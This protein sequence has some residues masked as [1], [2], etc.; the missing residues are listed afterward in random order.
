[1][2]ARAAIAG[3]IIVC[4]AAAGGG[5]G[6]VTRYDVS[7]MPLTEVNANIRIKKIMGEVGT[8]MIGVF[9]A[10]WKSTPHH[11]T[12]EQIN[13]GLSGAF[14]IITP[15][16]PHKTARLQGLLIPADVLHG[17]DVS[18]ETQDPLLIEFQPVRRLDFPPE[19]EKVTFKR[20]DAPS[21]APADMDLDFRPESRSW[22][23]HAS[24]A[25]MN[26][27][28]GKAVALSAWELR[29][30]LKETVEIPPQVTAAET[31]LYVLDG[32]V[33]VAVGTDRHSAST[34]VLLVIAPGSAAPR[35]SAKA[36][37]TV[38]IF[39]AARLR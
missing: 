35:V 16:T 31:F 36:T 34:G 38:L 3:L 5:Q 13:V 25:R 29:A 4:S 30:T 18:A 1:M 37:S 8:F 2:R 33:D 39:E 28:N 27:K 6:R 19:R 11:H 12:H 26:V 24:G 21:P 23:R 22:Q 10:G 9:K 7:S 20:A 14:N 17:N 32:N 15:E